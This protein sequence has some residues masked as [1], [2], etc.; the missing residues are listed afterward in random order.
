MFLVS[1]FAWFFLPNSVFCTTESL[2]M[3]SSVICLS[4]LLCSYCY[5]FFL[6]VLGFLFCVCR[7]GVLVVSLFDFGVFLVR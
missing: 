4:V 7:R 1:C 3:P 6:F 2:V 5:S